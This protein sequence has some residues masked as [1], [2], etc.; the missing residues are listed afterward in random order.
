[1]VNGQAD[2]AGVDR[3]L[4]QAFSTRRAE[5]LARLAVWGAWTAAAAQAAALESRRAKQHLVDGTTLHER[6]RDQAE[7]HGWTAEQFTALLGQV[8]AEPPA[9]GWL[10]R[11]ARQLADPDGGLTAQRSTFTRRDVLRAWCDRLP[12]GAPA[13]RVEQLAD[14]ALAADAGIA[15]RLH[16]TAP[17]APSHRRCPTGS[18]QPTSSR[19]PARSPT[20]H[21]AQP[22]TT[23]AGRRSCAPPP[24]PA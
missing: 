20:P 6:W 19:S 22:P 10:E 9:L 15:V 8:T 13:E 1:M 14:A 23:C 16:P 2:L 11:T 17:A 24:R 5:I 18:T 3:A 12:H 4:I 21:P 7:Q